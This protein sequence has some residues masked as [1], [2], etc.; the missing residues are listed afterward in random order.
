[1]SHIYTIKFI[2]NHPLNKGRKL[3]SLIKFIKWQISSR[4]TPYPI[5]FDY[6][7]RSK[8]IIKKG[9]TGATGNLYCGLHEFDD[10]SFLLHFLRET[11]LFID[12]GANVGSYTLL[13]ASEVGAKTI[14][15]EPIP[16]TFNYLMSNIFLNNIEGNV[17]AFNV[18]LGSE[19]GE[20]RFTKLLDTVNHVASNEDTD[21][22]TVP[23]R[24]FDDFIELE[25]PTLIKID[26][27]G[28]ET[29]VLI[30][31]SKALLNE[32]LKGIIIELNGAGSRY[33]N[34]DDEIHKKLLAHSFTPFQYL[35]F[36]RNL[37][38]IDSYGT[39][40]TIY[41]KDFEF[42]NQRI[43]SAKKVKINNKTF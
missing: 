14:S 16:E 38:K 41:I 42:V 5:I 4:L 3:K 23:V 8:F 31:M 43:I 32:N 36:K 35:P 6:A 21:T 15:I 18:G 2:I 20:L 39:H 24:R 37:K 10:M 33:G 22:I 11:D 29:D 26:V 25:K 19:K 34:S 27:E 13:G 30:G 28:F 9:L 40:N 17:D 12:I 1:M 7:Q